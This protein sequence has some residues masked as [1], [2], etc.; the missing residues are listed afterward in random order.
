MIVRRL[1]LNPFAGG[2]DRN[3]E[4]APGLNVVLGP[5]EAGKSTLAAAL[6]R[7]LFAGAP[8]TQV[9]F[10]SLIAPYLPVGQGNTARASLEFHCGGKTF[11]LERTWIAPKSLASRLFLDDGGE[12]SDEGRIQEILEECLGAH[13]GT[14][15]HV[16]CVSQASLS[17]TIENLEE[18]AGSGTG[19]FADLLRKSLYASDGVAID[20]FGRRLDDHI[21][22]YFGRWDPAHNAPEKGR[23]IDDPW[24]KGAGTILTAYYDFARAERAFREVDGYERT[25]DEFVAKEKEG[26]D[27][28]SALSGTVS[29][30]S[31]IAEDARRRSALTRDLQDRE[32]E[33]RD[34]REAI[35][36]WPKAEAQLEIASQSIVTL[37]ARYAEV[38]KELSE[39]RERTRQQ[40]I[41]DAFAKA[42]RIHLRVL[43]EEEIL[44]GLSP[45]T[46]DQIEELRKELAVLQKIEIRISARKLA[47]R[48]MAKSPGEF[49]VHQG[50]DDVAISLKAGEVYES[51]VAGKLVLTHPA[52]TLEVW[53]ADDDAETLERQRGQTQARLVSLLERVKSKTIEDAIAAFKVY[54]AQRT[55]VDTSR[56]VLAETLGEQ[57][58]EALAGQVRALRQTNPARQEEEITK[59]LLVMRGEGEAKRAE[60]RTLQLQCD[61]WTKLYGSMENLLT[62]FAACKTEEQK[63]RETMASSTPLPSGY[64]DAEAFLAAYEKAKADMDGAFRSLVDIQKA[65]LEFE[66]NAPGGTRKELDEV[67]RRRKDEFQRILEQGRAYQRIRSELDRLLKVLDNNLFTSYRRRAEEL[68][69]RL[70]LERHGSLRMQGALPERIDT[71][72][73][74][75]TLA[76]LSGGTL[77]VLAIAIRIAMAEIYL[78]EGDGFIVLDDPL[79]NLDP[80]RQTVAAS[81]LQEFSRHHQIVVF[82]CYPSHAGLLGGERINLT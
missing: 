45:I 1:G 72:G 55:K 50:T 25:L 29:G 74:E 31:A 76:Q 65:R 42:E 20:M 3:L 77:D 43:E 46:P 67:C 59:E 71:G 56:R 79:V 47:L 27:R 6:R 4:F 69:T 30:Q 33:L 13:E 70:T 66:K 18:D 73:H 41:R 78:K 7:V 34:L 80:E 5:N 51:T 40:K 48:L 58:F 75:L 35:E 17:R 2:R 68:L 57:T 10:R 60:Q 19:G 32:K 21:A 11:R 44:K 62:K 52:M 63:T 38:E 14:Y 81:I 39:A 28:Y 26:E 53:S 64:A 8:M 9:R 16:L 61:A 24:E 36:Q 15:E 22:Q 82:T 54:D 37:L 23:G 49:H 12:L